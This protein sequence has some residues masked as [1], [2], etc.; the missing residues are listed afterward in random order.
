[1]RVIYWE[2]L[3]VNNR[4]W[5]PHNTRSETG[6]RHVPLVTKIH[7]LRMNFFHLF[8]SLLP[9]HKFQ[10]QSWNTKSVKWSDKTLKTEKNDFFFFLQI[11]FTLLHRESSHKLI[12]KAN[13]KE[14]EKKFYSPLTVCA[15]N[16]YYIFIFIV[17]C[18]INN[19]PN[20]FVR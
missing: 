7:N 8:Y 20:L 15:W 11:P 2:A 14:R 19:D 4:F 9:Y 3:S 13:V 16:V 1:M 18:A 5:I 12:N 10:H 6:C 17:G